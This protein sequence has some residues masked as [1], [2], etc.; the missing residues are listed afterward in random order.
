MK[1]KDVTAAG[2]PSFG[3]GSW[4]VVTLL[5][6][7]ALL[8]LGCAPS[9]PRVII[10]TAP[11]PRTPGATAATPSV[12]FI[13]FTSP[14]EIEE[15]LRLTPTVPGGIRMQ[16]YLTAEAQGE[17]TVVNGC[18][19]IQAIGAPNRQLLIWP[20]ELY[21][22]D[23]RGG[24]V[25]ILDVRSGEELVRV[26]DR[27]RVGGGQLVYEHLSDR[28][29]AQMPA[30]CPGPYWAVGLGLERW[31]PSPTALP[32]PSPQP[33]RTP[34]AQP[35]V[36]AERAFAPLTPVPTPAGAP[37]ADLVLLYVH[38]GDLWRADV[39]G[40][41]RQRLTTGQPLSQRD[42]GRGEGCDWGR[43][44][45]G[46]PTHVSPD[47][48]W[49]VQWAGAS[50]MLLVDVTGGAQGWLPGPISLN[51][52]WSPDGRTLAWSPDPD[53]PGSSV[54]VVEVYAYDTERGWVER[55][56]QGDR[57]RWDSLSHLVWSPDGRQIAFTCCLE[58]I[59]VDGKYQGDVWRDIHALD[60][61]R[62][63]TRYLDRIES[64]LGSGTSLC[65]T[66]AGEITTTREEGVASS[67]VTRPWEARRSP[68]GVLYA[69]T[70]PVD[71]EDRAGQGPSRLTVLRW[72]TREVVWERALDVAVGALR[73]SPDGSSLLLDDYDPDTPIWR[74]PSDG[75]GEPEVV[76]EAG[77]LIDVVPQWSA[78]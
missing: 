7:L 76:I 74:L 65:W 61:A 30:D 25:R 2:G 33:S 18:L 39:S 47:G 57:E 75:M 56:F 13:T 68:D 48:R 62:G 72:E 28:V 34:T 19:Y 42:R 67:P 37:G 40:A 36:A 53:A 70:D 71:P 14:E 6:V 10:C 60:V 50:G 31:E 66:A 49:I 22:L 8:V 78:E 21:A 23:E 1:R 9:T 43:F 45:W 59:L 17:L 55:L 64:H 15:E 26:G 69:A 35:T 4:Q 41:H 44:S 52:A 77:F 3:R 73:W 54:G 46:C 11:A 51:V 12:H 63:N 38:D 32:A 24:T 29:R 16:V 27:I 5:V 20:P 58:E